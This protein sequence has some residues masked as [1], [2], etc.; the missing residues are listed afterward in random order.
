MVGIGSVLIVG[1]VTGITL[2]RH[3][4]K[5]AARGAFVAGVAV[6]RRVRPGQRETIVVLLNLV[7]RNL[8]AAHGVALL[9]IGAQL[10]AMNVGMTILAALAHVAEYRL[11]VALRT[12]DR[13]VHAAQRVSRLIVIEF[14][15]R[16]SRGPAVCGVAVLAGNVQ[17]SVRA[18]GS[19]SR[20]PVR[21]GQTH[22]Q[23]HRPQSD[24]IRNAPRPDH[25]LALT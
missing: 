20:L 12:S 2:R 5:L 21:A 13:R 4:L 6:H 8:P 18:V 14:R 9:A 17:I 3:G 25:A 11:G 23:R 1:R 19:T 7:D 15:H 24:E 10:P 16:A 22:G